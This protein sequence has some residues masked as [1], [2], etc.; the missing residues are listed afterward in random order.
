MANISAHKLSWYLHIS[1]SS[2]HQNCLQ[3][4]PELR[5]REG[6]GGRNSSHDPWLLQSYFDLSM[7]HVHE[8]QS[9]NMASQLEACLGPQKSVPSWLLCQVH[10]IESADRHWSTTRP[11]HL[12]IC[13][14][15]QRSASSRCRRLRAHIHLRP[16][17][18][19]NHSSKP[20]RHAS[21]VA[22]MGTE[23]IGWWKKL[24]SSGIIDAH[25]CKERG[26]S[27]YV[28]LKHF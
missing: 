13:L 20:L 27:L 5:S 4:I 1:S 2:T 17:S 3:S 8:S 26:P 24:R 19:S 21:P 7:Y 16:L 22:P 12:D 28:H 11:Y 23:V 15:E 14:T 10:E 9:D 18:A 25:S 6:F